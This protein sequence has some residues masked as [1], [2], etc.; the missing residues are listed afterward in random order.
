MNKLKEE[1]Y[2]FLLN[3]L[4][5]LPVLEDCK[6]CKHS[7]P[8][9]SKGRKCNYTCVNKSNFKFNPLYDMDLKRMVK[10]IIKIVKENGK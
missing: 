4:Y 3:N 7:D 9:V 6:Y 10:D 1:L 2:K 8:R 5:G